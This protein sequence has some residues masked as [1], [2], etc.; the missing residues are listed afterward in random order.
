MSQATEDLVDELGSQQTDAI[1]IHEAMVR[2]TFRIVGLTLFS[3]ELSEASRDFGSALTE[4]LDWTNRRTDAPWPIPTWMPT[5][6]NRRYS[7]AKKVLDDLIYALI[8]E[9]RRSGQQHGDLLDMLLH[10]CD[11]EMSNEQLRDELITMAAAG[12]ET[13]ANALSWTWYLLSRHPEAAERVSR[14][15]REVLGDR[16]VTLA[17]VGRLQFTGRVVSES[18]RLFPPVWGFDRQAVGEDMIGDQPVYPGSLVIMVPYSIHRDPAYWSNPEGF[19]PDRFLPDRQAQRPR[20][21]Y[22][23]FGGGSRI[24][25]GKAFAMMEAKIAVALIARRWR[26]DLVP[27]HPVVPEPSVTLRPRHGVRVMVRPRSD[28]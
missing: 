8:D 18:M 23:P 21:A 26:L 15:A 3:R 25:I 16:P 19:D 17:D 1:D 22:L 7:K 4:V 20:F 2:L 12:H 6:A 9:R 10:A 13:T 5:L 28:A 11:G 27:G 14:E 24:C